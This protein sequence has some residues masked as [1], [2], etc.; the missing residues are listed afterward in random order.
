MMMIAVPIVVVYRDKIR[1]QKDD[2]DDDD[3]N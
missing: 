1:I 2:D 3:E